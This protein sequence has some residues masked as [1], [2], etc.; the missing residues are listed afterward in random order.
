MPAYCKFLK[1]ISTS[2]RKIKNCTTIALLEECSTLIQNKSP[3]KLKDLSSFSIPCMIHTFNFDT[4]LCDLGASVNLMPLLVYK[5]LGLSEL[6]LTTI[7]LQLVDHVV[8]QPYRC[9]GGR[10][11]KDRKF[12]GTH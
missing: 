7:I 11:D 6:K 9:L 12:H 3:L 4:T 8:R 10:L 5:K 2:K 1:E